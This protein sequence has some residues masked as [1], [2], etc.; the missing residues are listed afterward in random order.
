[1]R[2]VICRLCAH[3]DTYKHTRTYTILIQAS[4]ARE[5]RG[6]RKPQLQQPK[7]RALNTQV[8]CAK[9]YNGHTG[10][11]AIF[12]DQVAR[13]GKNEDRFASLSETVASMSPIWNSSLNTSVGIGF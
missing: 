13:K 12:T 4:P 3:T 7:R 8:G 2:N 5:A 11:T 10:R 9:N 6:A 1:M